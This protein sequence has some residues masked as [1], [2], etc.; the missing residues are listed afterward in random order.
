VVSEAAKLSP[1][2]SNLTDCARATVVTQRTRDAGSID[3]A[4]GGTM[5]EVILFHHALGVTAATT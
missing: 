2:N 1:G 3:R 4:K 5:A